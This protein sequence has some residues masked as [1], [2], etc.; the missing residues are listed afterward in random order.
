MNHRTTPRFWE[1]YNELPLHIREVADKNFRL[2]EADQDHPSLQL[3]QIDELW[4]VRA[5]LRYRA[6]GIADPEWDNTILWFWIGS[7]AEYDRLLDRL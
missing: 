7:H 4:S 1:A 6:L 3:K 2:L 5:G